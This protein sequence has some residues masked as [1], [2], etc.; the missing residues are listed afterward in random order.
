MATA[1]RHPGLDRKKSTL[2]TKEFLVGLLAIVLGV[3]NLYFLYYKKPLLGISV[4]L[5]F[6]HSIADIILIVAG[7]ILWMTAYKLW[8]Y[9]W[10]ASRFI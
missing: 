7:L 10:H 3:Y 2:I 6:T 9:K 8:R 5:D 1:P 4:S